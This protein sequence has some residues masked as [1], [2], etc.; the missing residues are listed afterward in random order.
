MTGIA[1]DAVARDLIG[2]AGYGDHFGHG[3]GHGIGLEVHEAPGLSPSS[4]FTLKEGMAVTIEPGVYVTGF[5][6]VRIEDD[7]IVTKDGCEII[8]AFPKDELIEVGI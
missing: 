5:G 2:E 4:Q 7:V 1:V 8:T 6:G 3:L